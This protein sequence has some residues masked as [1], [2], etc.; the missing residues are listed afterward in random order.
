MRPFHFVEGQG[1]KK[2]MK[3]IVPA[4][5]VPSSSY[6]KTKLSEKLAQMSKEAKLNIFQISASLPIFGLKLCLRRV[7]LA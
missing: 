7:S 3:E 6:I 1:F 2:L 4:F 5:K